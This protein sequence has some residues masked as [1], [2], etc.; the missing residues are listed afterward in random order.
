MALREKAFNRRASAECIA[1]DRLDRLA[2]KIGP[3]PEG[4]PTEDE[5]REILDLLIGDPR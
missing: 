1:A 5:I 3:I 4:L 2:L